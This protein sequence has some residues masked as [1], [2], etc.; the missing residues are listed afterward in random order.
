VIGEGA[1]KFVRFVTKPDYQQRGL[2][3]ED[4]ADTGDRNLAQSRG[5]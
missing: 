2:E 4:E 5:Q 3:R 1:A